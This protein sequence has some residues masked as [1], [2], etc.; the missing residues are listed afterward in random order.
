M[1]RARADSLTLVKDALG[2]QAEL[3]WADASSV[4]SPIN[5]LGTY[6]ARV[7]AD[8]PDA[9]FEV[10]TLNGALP[11]EGRGAWSP[12]SGAVFSGTARAQ[13]AK[14]AELRE[15]LRL[16]GPEDASG[17]VRLRWSAT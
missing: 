11:I 13:P 4:L 5:P 15:L 14:A 6:R 10:T 16:L 9:K 2:G 7:K 8:G 3:E 17:V 1:L 12:T